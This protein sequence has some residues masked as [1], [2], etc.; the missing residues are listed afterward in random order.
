MRL[1][2]VDKLI[3]SLND[4]SLQETPNENESTGERRISRMVYQ[5][6]QNCIRAVEEQPTAYDVDAVAKSRKECEQM[7]SYWNE[8]DSENIVCPYC[9]EEYEPIY[10][11]TYIGNK[12]VDCFTE[13]T[14]EYVCDKCGKKF[15]MYGYQAG[16]RYCTETIDGQATDEE[17]ENLEREGEEDA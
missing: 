15:T 2:D 10:E 17:I 13:D 1:I 11:E 16:W 4:Y 14:N 9:G 8:E 5:T 3:L 6:I 7:D 12:V